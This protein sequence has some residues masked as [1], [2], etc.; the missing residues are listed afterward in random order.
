[1]QSITWCE[2]PVGCVIP[3]FI[4]R[5]RLTPKKRVKV[6]S[7]INWYCSYTRWL[8]SNCVL[9]NGS[10]HRTKTRVGVNPFVTTLVVLT[11]SAGAVF[12][13]VCPA[14]WK[15]HFYKKATQRAHDERSHRGNKNVTNT[16]ISVH[17][18]WMCRVGWRY[19]RYGSS[20]S[21]DYC[22]NC[23]LPLPSGFCGISRDDEIR[24]WVNADLEL[25]LGEDMRRRPVT[26][27]VGNKCLWNLMTQRRHDSDACSGSNV[28][29][30][31]DR[32]Y[33]PI[34]FIHFS[35]GNWFDKLHKSTVHNKLYFCYIH[36]LHYFFSW[37]FFKIT[38]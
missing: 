9:V 21:G 18:V 3:K 15:C 23:S 26:W 33:Q 31:S 38:N 2:I 29:I 25:V 8:N 30:P 16:N 19:S 35:T 12:M 34:L 6:I 7:K 27:N 13:R 17:L 11:S 37:Y 36:Y 1:M 20:R 5:K 28:G 10:P 14:T 32:R 4:V 22:S 24:E